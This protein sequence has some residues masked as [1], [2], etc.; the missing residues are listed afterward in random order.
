VPVPAG[1]TVCRP[2]RAFRVSIAADDRAVLATREPL[3]SRKGVGAAHSTASSARMAAQRSGSTAAACVSRSR[4]CCTAV[5][6]PLACV[7]FPPRPRLGV[8]EGSSL[9]GPQRR[10]HDLL[11]RCLL[12]ARSALSVTG[13]NPTASTPTSNCRVIGA[14]RPWLCPCRFSAPFPIPFQDRSG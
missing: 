7:P 3:D 4:A 14:S 9:T 5:P 12:P 6:D 11:T 8:G 2:K 10:A 13:L 1:N